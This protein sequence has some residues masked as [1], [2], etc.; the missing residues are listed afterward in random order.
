MLFPELSTR[1]YLL[2]MSFCCA[3]ASMGGWFASAVQQGLAST[4]ACAILDEGQIKLLE[5][6]GS[7]SGGIV[8]CPLPVT[9]DMP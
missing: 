8:P 7:N 4:P 2:T 5:T 9:S 3:A 1:D 6:Y